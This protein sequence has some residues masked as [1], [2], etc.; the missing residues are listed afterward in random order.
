M[1]RWALAVLVLPAMQACTSETEQAEK[2]YEMVNRTGTY[3]EI[4]DASK[5]VRNLYLKAGNEYE[6]R[7]WHSTA[8]IKCQTAD[9]EGRNSRPDRPAIDADL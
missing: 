2:Q 4:C 8:S 7:N 3:G 6:Y 1:R 9:Y 5:A